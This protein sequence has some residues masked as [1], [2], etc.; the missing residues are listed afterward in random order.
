[1]LKKRQQD[2]SIDDRTLE[3]RVMV[4]LMD[5]SPLGEI[6]FGISTDCLK[7]PIKSIKYKPIP[8]KSHVKLEAFQKK[9]S[10]PDLSL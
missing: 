1:V 4:K 2:H 10:Q 8:S 3:K 6:V 5:L 9:V 7:K